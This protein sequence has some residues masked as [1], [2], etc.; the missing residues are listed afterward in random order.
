MSVP[1]QF[2]LDN[3][4]SLMGTPKGVSSVRILSKILGKV[5]E[6]PQEAKFRKLNATKLMPK[7]AG[8]SLAPIYVI[9][10]AGFVKQGEKYILPADTNLE[11]LQSIHA[12][13]AQIMALSGGAGAA[14]PAAS[15]SSRQGLTQKQ[16]AAMEWEVEKKR[17]EEVAERRQKERQARRAR[18]AAE[19]AAAEAE[20]EK[21]RQEEERLQAESGPQPNAP[22][23]VEDKASAN[24][25]DADNN[26][27]DVDE[28]VGDPPADG[29]VVGD[30]PAGP[31]AAASAPAPSSGIDLT[32]L[33]SK[34]SLDSNPGAKEGQVRVVSEDGKAM[35][36]R[37]Q[38]GAWT[39][40]GEA[41]GSKQD[42]GPLDDDMASI[43]E[44][45]KQGKGAM[46]SSGR[47]KKK[48]KKPA[49]FAEMTLEQRH[50]WAVKERKKKELQLEKQREKNRKNL[51]R[52]AADLAEKTEWQR[53]KHEAALKKKRDREARRAKKRILAKIKRDRA[54]KNKE[55]A[56]ENARL[57]A[58]AAERRRQQ[59]G[60]AARQ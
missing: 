25:A 57:L 42:D 54:Q 26:S 40:L 51:G 14:A 19:R 8:A 4:R 29:K 27:M 48:S 1:L 32:T 44:R 55:I 37:W 47:K 31:V 9:E 60:G 30:P 11:K 58:E 23:A 39:L 45:L 52:A 16:I 49:N 33:P 10:H 6:K 53:L 56:A 21:K 18:E 36:Y 13:V 28:A 41:V 17:L 24:G 35:A 12:Q 34:S 46:N 38:G 59:G 22:M 3:M 43:V 2:C 7:L 15:G 5:L 50:A 20:A